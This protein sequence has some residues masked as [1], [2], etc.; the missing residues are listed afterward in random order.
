MVRQLQLQSGAVPVS[1]DVA[2]S[3]LPVSQKTKSLG[4]IMDDYLRFDAHVN[5]TVS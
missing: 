1:V 2:G 5:A 3:I 4:V